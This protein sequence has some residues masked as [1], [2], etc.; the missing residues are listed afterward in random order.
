[1]KLTLIKCKDRIVCVEATD[2]LVEYKVKSM[3]K[4]LVIK[5]VFITAFVEDSTIV[6]LGKEEPVE[7]VSNAWVRRWKNFSEITLRK[8]VEVLMR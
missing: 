5:D 4:Y 2:K 7:R 8:L 3:N 1:M 6:W